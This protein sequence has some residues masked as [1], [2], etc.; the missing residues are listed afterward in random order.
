MGKLNGIAHNLAHSFTSLMNFD[1][2][3]DNYVM[4]YIS[5]H[6]AKMGIHEIEVEVMN[7]TVTPPE[8][9]LGP[10][11]KSA[12]VYKDFLGHLL[13]GTGWTLN[14][15]KTAKIVIRRTGEHKRFHDDEWYKYEAFGEITLKNGRV[16][17][18]KLITSEWLE[19]IQC[20]CYKPAYEK[21][22]EKVKE[23]I[24]RIWKAIK[25]GRDKS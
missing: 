11:L 3:I 14:D 20:P 19:E 23:C 12:S 16:A 9:A 10:V 24:H 18:S 4:E 13:S 8:L 15:I 5:Y 21:V 6:M 1:P 2:G 17:R 22:V 25:K 7:G